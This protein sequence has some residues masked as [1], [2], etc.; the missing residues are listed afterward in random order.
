MQTATLLLNPK[1]DI[2]IWSESFSLSSGSG[3]DLYVGVTAMSSLRRALLRF[4][5]TGQAQG[6]GIAAQQVTKATLSLYVNRE[7]A[8][9][10]VPHSVSVHKLNRTLSPEGAS[11]AIDGT[12]AQAELG[13]ATWSHYRWDDGLW[14]QEGGDYW[15]T[16]TASAIIRQSGMRYEFDVT[17][18]VRAWL[19]GEPL[20][21][22]IVDEEHGWLLRMDDE[23][24]THTVKRFSSKEV[25]DVRQQPLLNITY[26]GSSS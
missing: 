5:V 22:N 18:D 16:P 17:S 12:G 19:L 25:A 1:V 21:G 4:D 3:E 8:Y 9:N 20:E 26:V 6:L 23:I 24:Q 15:P 13:D 2:C 14:T 7:T 11:N 10:R